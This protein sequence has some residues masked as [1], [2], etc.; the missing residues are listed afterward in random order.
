[1]TAYTVTRIDHRPTP[2]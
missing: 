2:P 1:M